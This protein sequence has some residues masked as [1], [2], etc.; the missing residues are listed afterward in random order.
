MLS[1][2]SPHNSM[3]VERGGKNIENFTKQHQKHQKN[4]NKKKRKKRERLFT[5]N[6][7]DMKRY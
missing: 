6:F 5:Y 2:S 7:A 3:T 4:R 1:Y